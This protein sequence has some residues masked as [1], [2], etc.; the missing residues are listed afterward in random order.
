MHMI[1]H[2]TVAKQLQIAGTA[3]LSKKGKV[4]QMVFLGEEDSL[5]I[6]PAL[7]DLMRYAD[8][9]HPRFPGHWVTHCGTTPGKGDGATSV[10]T[11]RE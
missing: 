10:P 6:V 5:V 3:F 7:G 2:Q 1:R 8:G 4:T 11:L 9:H